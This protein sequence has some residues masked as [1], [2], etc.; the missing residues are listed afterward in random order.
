MGGTR[1]LELNISFADHAFAPTLACPYQP[2]LP[3]LLPAS[4]KRRLPLSLL[5]PLLLSTG[6]ALLC[7]SLVYT[8]VSL[9]F[10]PI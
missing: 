8:R 10:S 3:T 4:P 9:D 2:I 1:S 6:L 5:C 7:G